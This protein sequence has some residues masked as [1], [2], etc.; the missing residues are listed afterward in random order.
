ML[1][2]IGT[3]RIEIYVDASIV[4]VDT[5]STLTGRLLP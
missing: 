3:H 2:F 1:K 4:Y 5:I